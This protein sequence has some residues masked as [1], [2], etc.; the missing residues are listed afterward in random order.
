MG[1]RK[2]VI[3]C[4]DV[5][6]FHCWPEA[7]DCL[8]YLANRHRHIFRIRV[9]FDVHDSNREIELI[10]KQNEITGFLLYEYGIGDGSCDFGSMSCEH[11]AERILKE[12]GASE[13]EVLEDGFGGARCS[14]IT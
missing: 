6:G 5:Q 7:P 1:I 4:L 3:C 10:T 8:Q 13:V 12:F 9:L 2:Q 14:A 11:I